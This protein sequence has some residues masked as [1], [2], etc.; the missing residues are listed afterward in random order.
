MAQTLALVT[1]LMLA[2]KLMVGINLVLIHSTLL[3]R[4]TCGR[5]ITTAL[6]LSWTTG[7][8]RRIVVPALTTWARTPAYCIRLT[9]TIAGTALASGAWPGMRHW[10]GRKRY[11]QNYC[12][13]QHP[14]VITT[15]SQNR[16]FFRKPGLIPLADVPFPLA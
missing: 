11:I 9:G 2:I 12:P 14:P 3:A 5:Q 10:Q 4:A 16:Q 13:Y 6:L 15:S 8:L 1:Q 7:P